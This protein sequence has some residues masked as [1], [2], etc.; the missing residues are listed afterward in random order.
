MANILLIIGKKLMFTHIYLKII[1]TK[2]SLLCV[3]MEE[4]IFFV[5]ISDMFS[6]L[7]LSAIFEFLVKNC[8]H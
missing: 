6:A 2:K 3:N 4:V 8:R 1:Q 5:A 7:W